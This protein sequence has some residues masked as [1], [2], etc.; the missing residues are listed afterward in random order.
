MDD[1][2]FEVENFLKALDICFK[3]FFVSN[4]GFPPQSEHIW[5]LLQLGLYKFETTNDKIIL[6][7]QELLNDIANKS[8]K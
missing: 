1:E 8:K 5:Q 2:T 7:V 3:S 6:S 4:C